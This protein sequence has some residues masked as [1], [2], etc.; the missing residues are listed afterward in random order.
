MKHLLRRSLTVRLTL[1][2][3]LSATLVLLALGFTV[4][5]AVDRHFVEQDLDALNGKLT[6]VSHA[7]AQVQTE[8]DLAKLPALLDSSLV[9]HHGLAVAVI[10]PQ[11]EVFFRT[12][13]VNFPKTLLEKPRPANRR[14]PVVWQAGEG[15]FRGIAGLVT[16]QL[17]EWPEGIVAVSTEISNHEAFMQAFRQTMWIIVALAAVLLGFLA[18]VATRHGLHPLRQLIAGA[19]EVTAS[20]LDYR[21]PTES[22]PIEVAELARSL[23]DMLARLEESFKRLSDFSSDLAHELRTPISNLMTQTQVSLSRVRT[24]DEY[25]DVLSSNAEELERLARTVSDMLF[26]AKA[27]NCL[28]V[29]TQEPVKMED[30]V[31]DLFDFYEALAEAKGIRL[32]RQGHGQVY[33]DKLMLRRAISNLLSN[34][35]RYADADSAVL[36][37]ISERAEAIDVG[38]QNTGP[39]I[40]PAQLPRL[41]D[42]FYR[43]DTSRH[44]TTE[45]AGLGLAIAASIVRAHG[46]SVR[47]SSENGTTRFTLSFPA[48]PLPA[49]QS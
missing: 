4:A 40:P 2:F 43:A 46:G 13:G 31:Q 5:G 20:R 12:S 26:L 7:F 19:S 21:L 36:V 42:R 23:N 6:L 29:P 10:D 47:V 16:T 27:E 22:I 30:E 24:S 15:H 25:Q 17:P 1:L 44:R 11:G 8:E 33:G 38:V 49:D 41:F 39:T 14:G 45:G 28:I 9:G 48:R 35:V 18:W 34:A 3:S 37:T 32:V